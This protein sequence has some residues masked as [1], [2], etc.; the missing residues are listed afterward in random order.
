MGICSSE[1]EKTNP[2]SRCTGCG[3]P[4]VSGRTRHPNTNT[5][6]RRRKLCVTVKVECSPDSITVCGREAQT[7]LLLIVRAEKGLTSGEASPLGWARRTSAYVR[8][9]RLAGIPIQTTRERIGDASVGRYRLTVQVKVLK[10][11]DGDSV[12]SVKTE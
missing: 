1:P 12:S 8:K 10:I 4:D 9:L 5:A 6:G 3:A 2:A 11:D 7:L